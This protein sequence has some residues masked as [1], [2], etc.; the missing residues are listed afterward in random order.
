MKNK[1]VLVLLLFVVSFFLLVFGFQVTN[2]ALNL[3]DHFSLKES[4]VISL[5]VI[6][7]ILIGF[8]KDLK[9]NLTN[10]SSSAVALLAIFSVINKHAL[11]L[12]GCIFGNGGQLFKVI[13]KIE[14]YYRAPLVLSQRSE[15]CQPWASPK[16]TDYTPLALFSH[17]GDFWIPRVPKVWQSKA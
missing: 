13:V 17:A 5:G 2:T 15:C 7:I 8:R 9:K 1:R 6:I 3:K 10:I 11:L 14:N 12:K 16:A 4:L